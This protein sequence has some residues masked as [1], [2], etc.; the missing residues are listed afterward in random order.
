MSVTTH[1]NPKNIGVRVQDESPEGRPD[2]D[3]LPYAELVE[4]IKQDGLK[5]PVFVHREGHCV[6]GFIRL[7]AAI[8]ARAKKVPVVIVESEA[9][10][11][12]WFN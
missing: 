11:E 12:R 4:S 7:F 3:N 8:Q 5:V 1:R 10:V 2:L 6:S 9:E